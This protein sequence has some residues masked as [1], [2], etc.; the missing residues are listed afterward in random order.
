MP[1]PVGETIG[2]YRITEFIRAGGM[3][4]VYRGVHLQSQLAVAIK[5]VSVPRESLLPAIRREIDALGKLRHPGIVAIRDSGTHRGIPWYAME[6]L[7]GRSLADLRAEL[8]G[9]GARSPAALRDVLTAIRRLCEPLAY[10]HGEGMVHGDL[11][12]T[13]VLLAADD[14]PVLIDFGLMTAFGEQPG[15]DA[16]DTRAHAVGSLAYM[17]PEQIDGALVDARAD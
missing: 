10:L 17:A 13:N 3:G 1:T 14:R 9:D 16:I 7:G 6:L 15:R 8:G 2:P 5:T 12:P 4:S 11:K